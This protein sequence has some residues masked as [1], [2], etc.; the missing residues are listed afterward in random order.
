MAR[1]AYC[2][3]DGERLP[4]GHQPGYKRAATAIRRPE[5]RRDGAITRHRWLLTKSWC[6]LE[7]A[8]IVAN[9][10]KGWPLATPAVLTPVVMI[11]GEH[12]E[13]GLIVAL[14]IPETHRSAG[15]LLVGCA[16]AANAGK[17]DEK[18][19]SGMTARVWAG[20]HCRRPG[21]YTNQGDEIWKKDA[22][23]KGSVQNCLTT[24]WFIWGVLYPPRAG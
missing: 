12:P 24:R 20:G 11:D 23:G 22:D 13:G 9:R 7:K 14:A 17:L 15:P 1:L 3:V 6:S 18:P 8:D 10:R 4:M 16:S 5:L 19:P 21:S 2:D